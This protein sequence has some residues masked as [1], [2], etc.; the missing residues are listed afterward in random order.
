[1]MRNSKFVTGKRE[2]LTVVKFP[3]IYPLVLL[4]I[5]EI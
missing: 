1:M 3:R 4:H 5:G 2:N